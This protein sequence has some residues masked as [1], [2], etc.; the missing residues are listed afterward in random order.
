MLRSGGPLP[1]QARGTEEAPTA[2]APGC[3]F[4]PEGS[5]ATGW[6]SAIASGVNSQRQPVHRTWTGLRLG[7]RPSVPSSSGEPLS[8]YGGP[9]ARE[10][11]ADRQKSELPHGGD[12]EIGGEAPGDRGVRPGATDGSRGSLR[13]AP[14]QPATRAASGSA[15][16]GR[17]GILAT[18]PPLEI[19]TASTAATAATAAPAAAGEEAS[20]APAGSAEDEHPPGSS[21]SSTFCRGFSGASNSARRVA[22]R[23]K[24][25]VR[26]RLR[27]LQLQRQK[28]QQQQQRGTRSTSAT[29]P[30]QPVLPLASSRR[31]CSSK[32]ESV[33]FSKLSP[34]CSYFDEEEFR[35][36]SECIYTPSHDSQADHPLSFGD[37]SPG[38][39]RPGEGRLQRTNSNGALGVY[40]SPQGLRGLAAA[41]AKATAAAAALVAERVT[42]AAQ[43]APFLRMGERGADVETPRG[44]EVASWGDCGGSSLGLEIRMLNA[45]EQ[46]RERH[47]TRGDRGNNKPRKSVEEKL[48]GGGGDTSRRGDMCKNKGGPMLLWHETSS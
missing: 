15:A 16:A 47:T 13:R 22:W 40:P 41:A 35:S 30:Q 11:L 18:I 7:R 28:Q 9:L 38:D 24:Q 39:L 23:Y 37:T 48:T 17:N 43:G 5:A 29:N 46:V 6:E 12:S 4:A 44:S 21:R 2:G 8:P 25:Y 14:V 31:T 27:K 26:R 3:A 20:C 36:D 45:I 34:Q 32:G 33:P 19:P 10:T 42:E 1:P